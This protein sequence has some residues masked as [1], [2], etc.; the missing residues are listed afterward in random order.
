MTIDR[1]CLITL[2]ILILN[3]P[4]SDSVLVTKL[5]LVDTDHGASLEA[6]EYSG[7]FGHRWISRESVA[8]RRL[9]RLK[10]L[11]KR[12]LKRLFSSREG[13]IRGGCFEK[14]LWAGPSQFCFMLKPQ[15]GQ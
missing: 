9:A 11:M 3:P 15:A 10:N 4:G 14:P 8:G 13:G 1:D 12:A 7:L 2:L 6:G 5:V